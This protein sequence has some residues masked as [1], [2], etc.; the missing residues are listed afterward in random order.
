MDQIAKSEI[1]FIVTTVAVVVVTIFVAI[2]SYYLIKIFKNV[3]HITTRARTETDLIAED[4][5]DLRQN[6]RRDG[7]K[8]KHFTRFINNL[9]K[10]K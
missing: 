8:I 1:F 10:K 7:A 6:L 5:G 4:I 3:K 2:I 9:T